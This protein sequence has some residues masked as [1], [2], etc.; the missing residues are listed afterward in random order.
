MESLGPPD[1]HFLSAA[2][3][4]CELGSVAEAKVELERIAPVLRQHPDVLEV[5][6]LIHAQEKD[7][8]EG[9]AV[10]EK[11]VEVAPQRSNGWLRRAYALRRAKRGGLQAAWDVLLPAVEKFPEEPII[12]YNLSCYACQLGRLDQARQWLQGAV[13]GAGKEKIKSMALNDDDLAPLWEE[14]KKL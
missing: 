8:E 11:L 12:P 3:G 9:L 7:W 5:R 6:W 14:I 10:A 13:K 2:V 1:T 4:W